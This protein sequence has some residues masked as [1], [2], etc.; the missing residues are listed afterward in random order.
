MI[1]GTIGGS[2]ASKILSAKAVDTAV[3]EP[4]KLEKLIL[5]GEGLY[6]RLRRS[7]TGQVKKSWIFVYTSPKIGRAHV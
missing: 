2:M 3:L 7:S 1:G 6:L 4:G 5:D